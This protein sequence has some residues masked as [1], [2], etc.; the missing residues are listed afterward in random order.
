MK[1]RPVDPGRAR[2]RTG[3]REKPGQ[4]RKAKV[5]ALPA[6]TERAE[7]VEVSAFAPPED[8]PA[9]AAPIWRQAIAE[10][11]PRGLRAADLEGVRMM[12][13]A[14]LRAR[15]AA[16]EIERYGL[17]VQGQRGPMPNPMLKIEKDA[18][19]TYL[20]LAEQY[21]LTLASRM[22]LGLMTLVGESM[23]GALNRDLNEG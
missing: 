13:M 5:V 16:H 15:Q 7:V 18:T 19:A 21:G 4:A 6:P 22:R 17:L 20:R 12:C 8:L 3:N 11:E 1:G 23:L 9:D 14:A 10:L 2:R